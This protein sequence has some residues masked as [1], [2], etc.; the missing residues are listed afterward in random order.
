M[1]QSCFR[2]SL[3]GVT[4]SKAPLAGCSVEMSDCGCPVNCVGLV[5]CRYLSWA[6]YLYSVQV[7]SV[8]YPRHALGQEPRRLVIRA[9][10]A[11]Y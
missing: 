9:R 8:K 11:T 10:A 5:L 7:K 1:V 2:I 6:E 4:W 3:G